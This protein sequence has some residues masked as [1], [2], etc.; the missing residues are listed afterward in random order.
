MIETREFY[1]NE[2]GIVKV[3][4]NVRARRI[5]FR[6][7]DGSL[8]ITIPPLSTLDFVKERLAEN[9]ERIRKL[10]KRNP[11]NILRVGTTIDTCCF[12]I[13]IHSHS[14]DKLLF[15]FK[16]NQLNIFV[17]SAIKIE[18]AEF[19][20]FLKSKIL[21]VSKRIVLPFFKKRLD[22]LAVINGLKYNKLSLSTGRSRL[23][24]CNVKKEIKLSVYLMFY[25][26]HLID[27]VI[28]HELAH[29]TEMNHSPR[30][31]SLCNAYCGGR[32]RELERELKKFI[33]PL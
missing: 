29:L 9:R 19:Q 12:K 25:P 8:N 11:V 3:K 23:G 33:F 15:T 31:H 24:V 7:K 30:F 32:E 17:P 20:K 13:T 6:V 4:Y 27:Y 14:N 1:D 18:E 10:F 16:E 28:M 2:F 5:I 22:E 21:H 26:Q